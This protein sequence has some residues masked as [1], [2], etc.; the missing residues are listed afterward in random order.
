MV[1]IT[2]TVYYLIARALIEQPKTSKTFGC[3]VRTIQRNAESGFIFVQ[4]FHYAS[5]PHAV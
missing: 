3:P 4:P 5:A 2:G 1:A